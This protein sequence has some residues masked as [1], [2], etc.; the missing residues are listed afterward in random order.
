V[1]NVLNAYNPKTHTIDARGNL[2]ELIEPG[3][4]LTCS[5]NGL[6]AAVTVPC[7]HSSLPPATSTHGL[8]G[9]PLPAI[10]GT[11]GGKKAGK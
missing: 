7:G 8:P 3:A 5:S 6:T 9:L 1:D 4:L 11:Y 10:G 2:L